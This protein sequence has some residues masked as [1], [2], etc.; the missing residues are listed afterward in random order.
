M[1]KP[2]K[3]DILCPNNHDQTIALS[4]EEFETTLSSG[5]LMFHCNTC[6]TDF[7][8]SGKVIRQFRRQFEKIERE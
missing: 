3:F 5:T 8:P 2:I 6:D 1:S 7:E 4:R